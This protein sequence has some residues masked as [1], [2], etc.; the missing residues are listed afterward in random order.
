MGAARLK[1]NQEKTFQRELFA[2]HDSGASDVPLR[3]ARPPAAEC[4]AL[5]PLFFLKKNSIP[6]TSLA[7]RR[8]WN[9]IFIITLRCRYSLVFVTSKSCSKSP[10][11]AFSFFFFPLRRRVQAAERGNYICSSSGEDGGGG[12]RHLAKP[13]GAL[14]VSDLHVSTCSK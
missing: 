5:P 4:V 7:V 3:P 9:L 12:S 6:R 14:Y 11:L 13:S 1:I 2:G 10:P 8:C